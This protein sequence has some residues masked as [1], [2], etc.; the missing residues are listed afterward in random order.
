MGGGGGLPLGGGKLGCGGLLVVIVIAL[1]LGV[2]PMQLLAPTDS[3]PAGAPH[4]QRQG[5]TTGEAALDTETA[6]FLSQVLASTEDPRSR[7]FP[8]AGDRKS[9]VEGKRG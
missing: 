5:A 3:G 8:Q 7:L 4:A 6:R 1:V 2:N 9:V